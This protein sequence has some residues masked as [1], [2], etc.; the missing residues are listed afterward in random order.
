MRAVVNLAHSLGLEAIAVG[1]ETE[2]ELA[3]LREMG[4]DS[5]QGLLFGAPADPDEIQ[6]LLLSD[7]RF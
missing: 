5:A 7:P 6:N 4:C 2:D 1:V 3:A